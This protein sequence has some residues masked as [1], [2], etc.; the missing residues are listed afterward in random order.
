MG[1]VVTPF[2][3]VISADA[4]DREVVELLEDLLEQARRGEVECLAYAIVR[5]NREMVWTWGGDGSA[6]LLVAAVAGLHYRYTAK[7]ADS[8][9]V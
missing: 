6:N 8:A 5:P 7:W 9:V 1:E 4:P 3:P 2:G